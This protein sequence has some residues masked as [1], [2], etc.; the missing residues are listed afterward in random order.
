M[1]THCAPLRMQ[2]AEI[3][4][5]RSTVVA[6]ASADLPSSIAA[7]AHRLNAVE[8]SVESLRRHTSLPSAALATTA[9]AGGAPSQQPSLGA[10]MGNAIVRLTA[11]EALASSE[12]AGRA[13]L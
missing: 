9:A 5:L 12:L 13:E 10:L 2:E 8:A 7:L 3:A 4:T 11:V 1:H 6:L